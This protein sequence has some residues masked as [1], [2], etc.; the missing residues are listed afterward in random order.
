MTDHKVRR[1]SVID[2]HQ[3]IGVVSQADVAKEIDGEK[4]GELVE[5]ISAAPQDSQ[6]PRTRSLALAPGLMYPPG[7]WARSHL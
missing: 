1:L 7:A 5:A 2:G 3:L 6:T 4:L